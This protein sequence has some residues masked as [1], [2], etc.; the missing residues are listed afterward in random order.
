ME[1]YIGSLCP[2][3]RKEITQSD[4][5]KVCPVC[6]MAHHKS[7]WEENRGCTTFGC[8]EQHYQAPPAS[9]SRTCGSCGAPLED[10]Q[11]FCGNCGTRTDEQ[12]APASSPIQPDPGRINIK[13]T[14]RMNIIPLITLIAGI[15]LLCVGLGTNIPSDY[16]SSYSVTEYVGGDAYNYIMEA[17]LRGGRIAG[18]LTTRAI[19]TAVGLLI[20]CVSALKLRIVRSH[21]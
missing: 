13:D 3:C 11:A 14:I 19:Y 7:C 1:N 4:P 2:H 5:V 15:V 6:G 8:S 10:A 21:P 9:P 12:P 17:S 20:S 18:A 16:L